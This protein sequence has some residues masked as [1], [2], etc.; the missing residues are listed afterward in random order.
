MVKSYIPKQGDLIWIHFKP[1]LPQ[2]PKNA[3]PAL[4]VSP[5]V[6]NE[7]RGLCLVLP[8]TTH[9]KDYPFEVR[10]FTDCMEGVIIAD[11][12]RCFDWRSHQISFISKV[13]RAVLE[14]VIERFNTLLSLD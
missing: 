5:S 9:I 10:F 2:N 8:V 3:R 7:T 6:Y 12:I 11:Q 14:E 1:D 13:E 4:I